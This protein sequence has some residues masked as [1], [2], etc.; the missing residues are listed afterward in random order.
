MLQEDLTLLSSLSAYRKLARDRVT[1]T[2]SSLV[3][4]S[5]DLEDLRE[6]VARPA[7]VGVEGNPDDTIAGGIPLEVHVESIRKGV[8]RLGEFRKR[9]VERYVCA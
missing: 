8:L 5:E 2:I 9:G 3:Q 6:R 4:L 7:L 1:L